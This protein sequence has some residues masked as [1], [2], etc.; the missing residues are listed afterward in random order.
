LEYSTVNGHRSAI[1][2]YHEPVDGF[3]IGKHPKV[4]NLLRG[5]SRER[6]PIP[7][8]VFIW[9]VQSVLDKFNGMP[10]NENLSLKDHSLKIITL[11]GLTA[12]NRGSELTK[13]DTK[14]MGKSDTT[15]MFQLTKPVKHFKQ[16]KKNPP[17]EFRKFDLNKKLCPVHALDVHIY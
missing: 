15:Y 3:S 10:D 17:I 9:D 16:G 1:S 6:P 12:P 8:Y 4:C 5:I 14:L 11:L 2:F 7:R 13:L